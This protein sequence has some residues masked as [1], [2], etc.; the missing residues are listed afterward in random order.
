MR[1]EKAKLLVQ[2]DGILL[3]P[4]LDAFAMGNAVDV[5]PR[6]RHVLPSGGNPQEF[7]AM[8]AMTCPPAHHL[9]A[10]NQEVVLREVDIGKGGTER[11]NRLSRPLRTRDIA[12]PLPIMTRMADI[13]GS[14]KFFDGIKVPLV[15][16]LSAKR[17]MIAFSSSDMRDAPSLEVRSERGY[18]V[19]PEAHGL[20]H[21]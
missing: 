2:A 10:I 21:R 19:C 12:S 8:G 5:D 11:G 17:R 15:P 14:N 7:P 16:Y 20:G 6:K 13:V 1:C 18:S 3:R 4:P 9:V